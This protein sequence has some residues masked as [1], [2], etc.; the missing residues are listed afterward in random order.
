MHHLLVYWACTM[1][2]LM[3]SSLR[4]THFDTDTSHILITRRMPRCTETHPASIIHKFFIFEKWLVSLMIYFGLCFASFIHAIKS[5]FQPSCQI[6]GSHSSLS[7][8]SLW[9]VVRLFLHT[10]LRMYRQKKGQTSWM[11]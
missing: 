7:S 9:D 5:V 3:N 6:R 10:L 4:I 1:V 8:F 11:S 2:M